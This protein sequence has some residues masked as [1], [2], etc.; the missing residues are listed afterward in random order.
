METNPQSGTTAGTIGGTLL[1]FLLQINSAELLK[2]IVLAAIGATVSFSV[3][4]VLKWVV[5]KVRRK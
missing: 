3:S 5:R 1:V 2:T 4:M